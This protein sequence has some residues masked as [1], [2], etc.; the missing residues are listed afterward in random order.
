MLILEADSHSASQDTHFSQ[1]N[2]KCQYTRKDP[3]LEPILS[4]EFKSHPHKSTAF[5]IPIYC[6]IPISSTSPK[7][8]PAG[9]PT[10][11]FAF[12]FFQ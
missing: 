1:K 4:Q 9:F 7:W 12:Q 10:D 2:W 6:Y 8:F 3:Q 11:N 5:L